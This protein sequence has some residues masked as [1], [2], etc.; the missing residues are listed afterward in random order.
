[1]FTAAS[2]SCLTVETAQMS[3]TLGMDKVG[4]SYTVEYYVAIKKGIMY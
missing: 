4:H 1:M 2:F 3:I